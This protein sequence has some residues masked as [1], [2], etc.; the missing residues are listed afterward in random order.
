LNVRFNSFAISGGHSL[1]AVMFLVIAFGCKAQVSSEEGSPTDEDSSRRVRMV[2]PGDDTAIPIPLRAEPPG[3]FTW[4]GVGC[5]QNMEFLLKDSEGRRTGY[6]AVADTTFEDIPG[7]V[8]RK[9]QIRG[10]GPFA[11]AMISGIQASIPNPPNGDYLLTVTK[12]RE[13]DYGFWTTCPDPR[14]SFS[15][16][17]I[18]FSNIPADTVVAHSYIV[19][20]GNV[21]YAPY[22]VFG[23][24]AGGGEASVSLDRLVSY[25]SVADKV[26]TL[27]AGTQS[28]HLVIIYGHMASPNTF[29]ATLNGTDI[30]DT[31]T[32]LEGRYEVVEIPLQSGRNLLVLAVEGETVDGTGRDTDSLIFVVQ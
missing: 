3:D 6:D 9:K 32:P 15:A 24:F 21:P 14:T 23:G 11:Q 1:L 19:S 17:G 30:A 4:L 26:T 27:S 20:L 10:E 5:E 2:A 28:V 22:A 25:A 8:Y 7:S 31:F 29:A 13:S 16:I 12:T 18:D